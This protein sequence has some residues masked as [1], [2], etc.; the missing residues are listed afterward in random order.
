MFCVGLIAS[1][2]LVHTHDTGEW[3]PL[4]SMVTSPVVRQSYDPF[5]HV[6]DPGEYG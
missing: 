6:K 5:V 3:L 4:F 1:K 2:F